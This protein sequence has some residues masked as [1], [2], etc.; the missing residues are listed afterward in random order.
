MNLAADVF[1][2]TIALVVSCGYLSW[3]NA[4]RDITRSLDVSMRAKDAGFNAYC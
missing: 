1:T 4:K 2:A 3:R